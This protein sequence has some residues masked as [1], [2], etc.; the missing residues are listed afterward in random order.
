LQP[1]A[2]LAPDPCGDVL[3]WAEETASTGKIEKG[4][5]VPPR[6]DGR[7]EGPEDFVQRP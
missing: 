6:L 7:R 3:R 5:T 1:R 4:V 2:C